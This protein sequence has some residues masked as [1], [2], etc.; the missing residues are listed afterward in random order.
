M[1]LYVVGRLYR[2]ET[3]TWTTRGMEYDHQQ[4]AG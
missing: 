2:E 4:A 3:A 1:S